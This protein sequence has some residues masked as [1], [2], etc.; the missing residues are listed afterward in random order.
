MINIFNILLHKKQHIRIHMNIVARRNRLFYMLDECVRKGAIPIRV[1][2]ID[3]YVENKT[4][5]FVIKHD[6][7]AMNLNSLIEFAK[8][9][10]N[11]EISGSYFF[12]AP[13][14][15]HTVRCYDFEQ[16]AKA[17]RAVL[18]MGHEEGLQ[19]DPVF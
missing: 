10:S 17:M 12:M 16:Q 8:Q 4:A 2:D 6:V 3:R 13:N 9:E 7:H 14:H 1:C 18:E 19:I 5:A 11:L 15:P